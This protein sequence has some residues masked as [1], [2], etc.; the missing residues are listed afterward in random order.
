MVAQPVADGL[1]EFG[2]GGQQG[3]QQLGLGADE[4]GEHGGV[5][6]DRWPGSRPEPLQELARVA[7]AAVGVPTAERGQLGLVELGG[8]LWGGER[9]HEG[10][11][12]L[13]GQPEEQL[14]GAGPVR[15]Q[16]R[17]ELHAGRGLG[18]NMVVAQ[19]DQ[20]LQLT[21]TRVHRL[22][23]AQPVAIGAQVVREL[24]AVTGI[25]LGPGGT[26][27]GRAA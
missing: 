16:E 14:L 3:G 27:R 21:G 24:V 4:L 12:K 25:G 9:G 13:G 11:G 10:Q 17:A 2:N 23:P 7:A 5:E 22:Q 26:P 8:G 20:G 6:P 1:I 19:P 18:G 15:V